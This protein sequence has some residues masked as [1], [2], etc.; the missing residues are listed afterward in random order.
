MR[1]YRSNSSSSNNNTVYAYI[2]E[3][4]Q[5]QQQECGMV[6]FNVVSSCSVHALL[7]LLLFHF[8]VVVILLLLFRF[9]GQL[10]EHE[11]LHGPEREV[12]SQGPRANM[13]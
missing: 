11:V 4:Q 5:Q 2:Q 9:A 7:F 3:Q 1:T 6:G 10:I 8:L 12:T 13:L